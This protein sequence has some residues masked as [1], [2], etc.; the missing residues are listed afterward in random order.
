[1]TASIASSKPAGKS[2]GIE[3]FVASILK[4]DGLRMYVKFDVVEERWL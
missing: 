2:E 1:M 4:R 3:G